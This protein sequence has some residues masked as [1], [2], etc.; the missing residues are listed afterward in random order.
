MKKWFFLATSAL[1]II[2]LVGCGD[3]AA[4][5]SGTQDESNLT[6]QQV[7]E[8]AVERQQNLENVHVDV[9]MEQ[10][11][12]TTVGTE[13][14]QF[15]TTSNLAM[16]MQQSPLAMFT[17]GTVSMDMLGET[18]DMPIEMY[19]T[20]QD[21]FYM[22]NGETNEWLKLPDEQYEQLLAQTGVPAKPTEQLKQLEQ[23]VEDFDFKQDDKNYLLTL[24]IEGDKF[25]EFIM[26]QLGT[27]LGEAGELSGDAFEKMTFENSTYHLKIA[28]DTFDTKEIQTDLTMLMDL[29]GQQMKTSS[30][31]TMHYSQ[32]DE[33]ED[34][35]IP[36]EVKNKAVS[37]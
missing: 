25:T 33:L 2:A 1:A 27:S 7:L 28:K 5:I 4:P 35:T 3:T 15:S 26:G 37:Q 6:V 23:F 13:S 12:E 34:I 32:Y 31:A 36:D 14:V 16:D 8:K 20:E 11:S 19:M 21:G 17:K 29:Q 22:L 18:I 30:Q 9:D 10:H 24:T